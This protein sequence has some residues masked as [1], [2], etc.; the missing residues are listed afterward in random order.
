MNFAQRFIFQEHKARMINKCQYRNEEVNQM[1]QASTTYTGVYQVY[2]NV[3]PRYPYHKMLLN[4]KLCTVLMGVCGNVDS[5][6]N[7]M[8]W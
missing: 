8:F 2:I 6:V 5:R 3:L 1:A 4:V 7:I